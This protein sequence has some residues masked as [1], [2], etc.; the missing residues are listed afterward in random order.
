MLT[1]VQSRQKELMAS[2]ATA[3]TLLIKQ[4]ESGHKS[5]YAANVGDR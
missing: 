2:G 1:D 4:E 5:I 3:V